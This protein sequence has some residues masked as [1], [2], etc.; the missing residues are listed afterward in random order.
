[1]YTTMDSTVVS[2]KKR[3]YTLP[4]ET[5][6]MGVLYERPVFVVKGTNT[7]DVLQDIATAS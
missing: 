7:S 3:K 6:V 5:N 1:M 2:Q 4:K